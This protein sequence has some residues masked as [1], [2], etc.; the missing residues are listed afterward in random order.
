MK[1][2]FNRVSVSIGRKAEIFCKDFLHKR[3]YAVRCQNYRYGRCEID[4][5]A[6]HD[7]V[8]VFVEVKF[9][10]SDF[11]GNPESFLSSEQEERIRDAAAYYIES[12]GWSG[13]VRFDIIS[14]TYIDKKANIKHFKDAF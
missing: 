2:D 6:E 7:R 11:F 14:V 8:L 3:G 10:K 4:I 1:I 9:R 13:D 12:V 5:I